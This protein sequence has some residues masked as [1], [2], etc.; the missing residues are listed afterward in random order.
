MTDKYCSSVFWQDYI[1]TTVLHLNE[2]FFFGCPISPIWSCKVKLF[3]FSLKTWSQ[4]QASVDKVIGW[5]CEQD[6]SYDCMWHTVKV[7][8]QHGRLIIRGLLLNDAT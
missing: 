7:Y 8:E 2:K 1:G 4:S 5:T 3:M 6:C